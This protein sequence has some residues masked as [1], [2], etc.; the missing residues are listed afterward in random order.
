MADYDSDPE[1][2][3]EEDDLDVSDEENDSAPCVQLG[4]LS[5]HVHAAGVCAPQL[6]RRYFPSKLGGRPAWLN[7]RDLP[8]TE[9]LTCD[10]CQTPL[11]FLL[12]VTP[13]VFDWA[14]Y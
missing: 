3:R 10:T 6:A 9:H 12:Q 1:E 7:P 5:E 14:V 4:F 8:P 11:R 13:L 2:Y